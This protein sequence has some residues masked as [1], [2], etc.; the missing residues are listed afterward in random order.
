[1]HEMEIL[2]VRVS[3][4]DHEVVVVLVTA[5][6]PVALPIAIGPREGAAIASAQAGVIAERPQTHDLLV[7]LMSLAELRLSRVQITRLEHG[8]FYAELVMADGRR[9]DCRPSDGIA[10]AVRV[11]CPVSCAEQVLSAAGVPVED[12]DDSTLVRRFRDFLEDVEPQD[13]GE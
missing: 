4:P 13:F 6:E 12:E 8:T 5:E 1:M 10:L 3:L 9:V 7:T 11:G 2:G